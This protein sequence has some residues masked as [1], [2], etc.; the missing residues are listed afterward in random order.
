MQL[1]EKLTSLATAFAVLC[2]IAMI[3]L[4]NLDVFSRTVLNFPIPL[5]IE[6]TSFCFAFTTFLALGLV[7]RER[8][9]ISVDFVVDRL[10]RKIHL[11]L[12]LLYDLV[13]IVVFTVIG[14]SLVDKLAWSVSVNDY[15]PS[16][17][18]LPTAV[19]WSALTLGVILLIIRLAMDAYRLLRDLYVARSEG[20][21]P[22]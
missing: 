19:P 11:L 3:V 15:I 18:H 5:A 22:E 9:E 10:P 6:L 2:L 12:R 7:V 17:P 4:T 13:G 14:W 16:D 20:R 8:R 21:Y 1:L